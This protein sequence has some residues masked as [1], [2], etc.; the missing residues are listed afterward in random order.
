VASSNGAV[1]G[2]TVCSEA[3]SLATR[4]CCRPVLAVAQVPSFKG[5]TAAAAAVL[6]AVHPSGWCLRL[7]LLAMRQQTNGAV[8]WLSPGAHS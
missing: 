1:A 4:P 6:A 2:P 8:A 5:T 3:H 7:S